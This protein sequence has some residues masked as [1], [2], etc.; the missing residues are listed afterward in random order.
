M[1]KGN[2]QLAKQWFET[3]EE[4]AL[5][6]NDEAYTRSLRG[7]GRLLVR[8][9]RWLEAQQFFERAIDAA[10]EAYD[11]YQHA[12][13]LINLAQTLAH[14][15]QNEQAY[16]L[17]K[18]ADEISSRW[19]YLI[20]LGRAENAQGD[21]CYESGDYQNAF[22]HYRQYCWH[23]ARHNEVEYNRAL[24]KV[25]DQLFNTPKDELS[26]I[27]S[28][29]IAYWSAQNMDRDYASLIDTLQ[30]VKKARIPTLP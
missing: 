8:Q 18:E 21:I 24:G 23:M 15:S 26:D 22:V 11:D 29:F 20:L 14:L 17:L 9:K 19:N 28:E 6:L 16:Q 5:E 13:N 27:V 4:T 2:L 7:Q 1:E 12:E 3:A 10:K 25:V 30:E